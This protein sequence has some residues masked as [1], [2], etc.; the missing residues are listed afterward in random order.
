M[1]TTGVCWTLVNTRLLFGPKVTS[2]PC[3][4]A[5]WA[6]SRVP[7]SVTSASPRRHC[8]DWRRFEPKE[9][10]SLRTCSCGSV[11]SDSVSYVP[12]P[13]PSTGAGRASDYRRGALA[14]PEPG[15]NL[16]GRQMLLWGKK[17]RHILKAW[18]KVTEENLSCIQTPSQL[19]Y[20][21]YKGT[22]FIANSVYIFQ[23]SSVVWVKHF[24]VSWSDRSHFFFSF[25]YWLKSNRTSNFQINVISNVFFF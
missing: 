6:W 25:L 21:S 2:H 4:A 19:T 13:R 9:A 23:V 1:G 24:S 11:L 10:R 3:A 14:P 7:P 8:R 5:T 12:A 17:K 16:N 18:A 20:W 22:T 15:H